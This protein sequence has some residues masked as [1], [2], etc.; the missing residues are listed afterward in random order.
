ML[1]LKQLFII[2]FF[3]LL[4]GNCYSQI[5]SDVGNGVSYVPGAEWVQNMCMYKNKL[6]V[7]GNF[8]KAG[9]INLNNG[10]C[11]MATWDGIKWDSLSASYTC[12][13]SINS[14]YVYNNELYAGGS[15]IQMGGVTN[16]NSIAKW[17]GSNW[18][19]LSSS[20]PD[21]RVK[22]IAYYGEL[23]VGGTFTSVGS[24]GVNRM[25]KFNGT[26]W[27]DVAGGVS[28]KSPEVL[29]MAAYK[30]KLYVGGFFGK[31]GNVW[32]NNI[33]CWDGV[34]WDTLTSGTDGVIASMLVDTVN[35]LLYV[36]GG[37]T[38]AGGKPILAVACWDGTKWV[39][40]PKAIT[41]GADAMVFYR[42]KLFVGSQ[43]INGLPTDTALA[44][45]DGVKWTP[46]T[47][48]NESITSLAV[49]NDE[50]YVGGGFDSVGTKKVNY[51]AR[52]SM[53][54]GVEELDVR[55][56]KFKVYPNPAKNEITIE[57]TEQTQQTT[58]LNL[59]LFD[60][61]GK[62]ILCEAIT[63][64]KQQTINTSCISKGIY[65]AHLFDEKRNSLATQKI[66]IH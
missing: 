47:G 16:A 37:I 5:W 3:I 60:N 8:T 18:S 4:T 41:P 38:K 39:D 29:A 7:N 19:A 51:I 33:A 9:N 61:L 30:N 64:I 54:V 13:G 59:C 55:N 14:F 27:S 20:Y 42:N 49:Y 12:C 57:L 21:N 46:V 24:L 52:L 65:L 25:A 2:H 17:D 6:Y 11:C 44:Y 45:F 35:N 23:C 10:S 50:L 62:E 26:T 32:A 56:S 31:A 48:P 36:G 15:F 1:G 43:S 63:N 40:I 58:K 22:A 53:P 28:Y 34:K 66:V